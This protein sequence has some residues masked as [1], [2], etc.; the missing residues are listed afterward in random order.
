MAAFG[1]SRPVQADEDAPG[2]FVP[3]HKVAA[4]LEEGSCVVVDVR[5]ETER[6]MGGMM[7]PGALSMGMGHIMFGANK[8]ETEKLLDTLRKAERIVC[9]TDNGVPESRC[10]AMCQWLVENKGLSEK[11]MHRLQGGLK[12]WKEQGLET[13][14][15][16]DAEWSRAAERCW[17]GRLEPPRQLWEVVGGADKGGV[18]VREGKELASAAVEERLSTGAHIEEL[19]LLGI[20]LCYR[21]VTGSG[22]ETGWIS[23]EIKDKALANRIRSPPKSEQKVPPKPLPSVEAAKAPAEFKPEP[24][25]ADKL[26]A[27]LEEVVRAADDGIGDV[28]VG[29]GGVEAHASVNNDM[30]GKTA[31]N[32]QVGSLT[33]DDDEDAFV[34]DDEKP[35]DI[36]P[37]PEPAAEETPAAPAAGASAAPAQVA[38]GGQVEIRGLKSRADING[39]RATVVLHDKESGRFEVRVEGPKGQETIRCKPENLAAVVAKQ[40]ANKAKGDAAFKQGHL[41][42]AISAYKAALEDKEAKEDTEFAATIQS[43]LAATYAKKGDHEAA[44]KAAQAAVKLRPNWS[45]GHSRAGLSFLQLGRAAEAQASYIKAVQFEPTVDGYLVGLRQA[46]EQLHERATNAT[47]RQIEA[48]KAKSEGNAALKNGNMPLAVAH[49]TMALAIIGPAAN[50]SQSMQQNLAIYASNRSA[51][52]AKLQQWEWALADGESAKRSSP[53]WFKAYLRIGAAYLGRNH[54]EHAYKTFLSAADLQGGYQEAMRDAAQAL[55]SIPRLESPIARKRVQRFSEDAQKSPSSARIFAIS[56]VHIDHGDSVVRWAEGISATEFKNDVLIVAGDLGDTFNAIQIGLKIFKRKFRRVF[57]VPGNHDMWIRPNTQDATKLK[58]KDSICKLLAL[59]DMCEKIGAE[60]MP[61]EVMRGVFV[62]P[63]LSW[64]SSSVMGAGYVSDDTL[65]YDAFCKWPMGDQVAHK[66]FVNW[67]DYFVQKLQKLQKERGQK[68]EVVTF[69]HFLPHESL[70]AGGAPSLASYS[71][72]LQSQIEGVGA[73]T[74]IWGHTHCNAAYQL[75][76]VMYQQHSLMGAEYGH[77]PHAKFLKVYDGA[78][79][80]Q[81]R[82]HDVY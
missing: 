34:P 48:E 78:L 77:S 65:V 52:F 69:S 11:A 62:V 30:T 21:R 63:L 43:N 4:W 81:P 24:R 41:E 73:K 20:R 10:G 17:M 46:T 47:N 71:I 82:S 74:H 39:C 15:D 40:S 5:E 49:Y 76:G 72:E 51:A 31:V 80:Q 42:Q 22:P 1:C 61:A 23:T 2:V 12:A 37:P 75:N 27:K 54:A 3:P 36:P 68:G 44:L 14:R 18:L 70:P 50:G 55:W 16:G 29:E 38:V 59:L 9:Y 57:Y 66:W 25:V 19:Q 33:F 67:N 35:E 60:M 6:N 13:C 26:E 32:D 28:A 79:V 7:L 58:F 64:W 45:K 56:D 8:P 53:N